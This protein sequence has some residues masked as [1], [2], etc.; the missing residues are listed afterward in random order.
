MNVMWSDIA[1]VLIEAEAR[2][3][4][5]SAAAEARR[6]QEALNAASEPPYR[7]LMMGEPYEVACPDEEECQ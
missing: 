5:M 3:R 1:R 4:T 2:Q 6:A 7:Y